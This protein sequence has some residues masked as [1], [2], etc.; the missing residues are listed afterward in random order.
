MTLQ[1]NSPKP[2]INSTLLASDG[3]SIAFI[4]QPQNKKYSIKSALSLSINKGH[5][6]AVDYP[7]GFAHLYE[8]MLF[9]SST[10]YKNSNALDQH[11]FEFHGQVNAWT[12]DN[13]TNFQLNCE[14]S[15]FLKACAIF[16]DKLSMPLFLEAEIEKEL[17][18]I[19]AEFNAQKDN[20]L[21]QLLSVQKAT[22]NPSHPFAKFSSGNKSSLLLS[23]VSEL[24]KMLCSYH[25]QIIS[26]NN[27]F[28]CIGLV[29]SK[30][31]NTQL[32]N[33]A[34]ALIEQTFLAYELAC[35]TKRITPKNTP[36][37][38]LYL[39]TQ[40]TRL[41]K[42]R[43]DSPQDQMQLCF[44][45]K[46]SRGAQKQTYKDASYIMLCHLF[47]SK[48]T[49][50]LFENLSKVN[51]AT[52]IQSY[53]KQIDASNVEICISIQLTDE[54][55]KQLL[56]VYA[57]SQ[58]YVDCVK[59]AG[60]AP[61]RLREKQQQ[62]IQSVELHGKAG[63]LEQCIDS[64]QS[65]AGLRFDD[66]SIKNAFT[67]KMTEQHVKYTLVQCEHSQSRLFFISNKVKSNKTTP[68]YETPFEDIALEKP[69]TITL[70]NSLQ[71]LMSFSLPRQNP[72][73]SNH[74]LMNAQSI[75]PSNV[76]E[77]ASPN[78]CFKFYQHT[79]FAKP[80]GECFISISDPNM[81]ASAEKIAIKR[82]W[83]ACLN[84]YLH[85]RFFDVELASIHFRVYSHQRGISIHTSG[86]SE[87]QLLL[88]IELINTLRN[89]KASTKTIVK[90]IAEQKKELAAK[91]KLRALNYLFS[92]L[93]NYYQA[94]PDLQN[95][96]VAAAQAITVNKV[97]ALQNQYFKQNS[98][99]SLLL[100]NW[101]L[102]SAKR[103]FKQVQT[104]FPIKEE[105]TQEST[106]DNKLASHEKIN[107]KL[108]HPQFYIKSG[109]H[110][111]FKRANKKQNC[112]VWHY[113]P[114]LAIEL[115]KDKTKHDNFALRLS[116][117]AFVLEK[118]LAYSIF[119]IIRE[120]HKMAYKLGAGYK[121]IG[122]YPGIALYVESPSHYP[123]KIHGAMKEVLQHSQMLLDTQQAL[124][125]NIKAEL[126]RQITPNERDI[127]QTANRV[128]LH[129]EDKNPINAFKALIAEIEDL[130]EKVIHTVLQQI[131]STSLA[132]VVFTSSERDS[133]NIDLFS[134]TKVR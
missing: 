58:A 73:M 75:S 86:F 53:Y 79:L 37:P 33:Q 105:S 16:F 69:E 82:V 130:N 46:D 43:H 56:S 106:I 81:H 59:Q 15:G 88:C 48:H 31:E 104:R 3:L 29:G 77:L 12:Q 112:V 91:P 84:E 99:E 64:S 125:E 74:H 9:T 90:H 131:L 124:L 89:F 109:E 25:Q 21:R 62:Y 66:A 20:P 110:F 65:M 113:I 76:V 52:D 114:A 1:N 70:E 49:G 132:Q 115:N 11:L 5:F 129:F 41:I 35:K 28:L 83:L 119:E 126:K 117:R 60:V 72:Y 121:P 39:P 27:M 45:I 4:E 78:I 51:F 107:P 10:N 93:N 40:L 2:L 68:Q 127:S 96:I 54:G 13:A 80:K 108:S 128:W 100:G 47:E 63:L 61:W 102:T 55:T 24:R 103:F 42:V 85:S 17:K 30:A 7:D 26:T 120:K 36:T 123:E 50:G 101:Q 111:H 6:D 133:E 18:A 44:N 22:C 32:K 94:K 14:T 97:L 116:A 87:R 19:D 23:S 98:I 38:P 118:L 67:Q 134:K 71:Q 57:L 34:L 92:Q 95:D 122:N 8:H